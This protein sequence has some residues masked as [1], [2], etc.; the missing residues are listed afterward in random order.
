MAT[1]HLA[2]VV[3]WR[4]DFAE[5]NA[6]EVLVFDAFH[7]RPQ[8]REDFGKNAVTHHLDMIF[9]VLRIKI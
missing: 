5:G 4:A 7:G 1:A 9:G 3:E 2:V 8:H 6:G